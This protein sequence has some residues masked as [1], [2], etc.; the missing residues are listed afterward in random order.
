MKNSLGLRERVQW[1]GKLLAQYLNRCA[2]EGKS[3]KRDPLPFL[4]KG[5]LGVE[6]AR[7][8]RHRNIHDEWADF[9]KSLEAVGIFTAPVVLLRPSQ[10]GCEFRVRAELRGNTPYFEIGPIGERG[11]LLSSFH[12]L[13]QLGE[14]NRVRL[15]PNCGR[16]FFARRADSRLCSARCQ[17]SAW[18]KTPAGRKARAEYMRSYRKNRRQLEEAKS[19]GYHRKRGRKLHVSLKKG[20]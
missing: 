17:Q 5:F 20:E 4:L 15:C 12:F 3:G 10:L 8:A 1:H 6:A 13:T 14:V 16:W 18:R 9:L 7:E 19:K 11:V 2:R